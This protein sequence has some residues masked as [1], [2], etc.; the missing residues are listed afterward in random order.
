[1]NGTLHHGSIPN[2]VGAVVTMPRDM[3][4]PDRNIGCSHGQHAETC[5]YAGGFA[6]GTT[7]KVNGGRLPPLAGYPSQFQGSGTTIMCR[8]ARRSANEIGQRTSSR[9]IEHRPSQRFM[10]HSAHWC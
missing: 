5:S 10:S 9:S 2:T 1:M 6:Q 4:N 7:L 8:M 3:V